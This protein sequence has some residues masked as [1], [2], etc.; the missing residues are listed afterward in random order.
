[1]FQIPARTYVIIPAFN[2]A[3]V[4]RSTVEG[5]LKAGYEVILVDDCST[6]DTNIVLERLN[7]HL[8]RHPVNLGQGASLQTGMDYAK[9]LNADYVIHFDADGQHRVEDIP[10]LLQPLIAQK[11]DITLGSR[12]MEESAEFRV[13]KR[14][15]ILLKAA[16]LVNGIFTGVWLS[17]AHNG[18]RGLSKKA[19]NKIE[20]SENGMAHATEILSEIHK[21]QLVVK[22]VPVKIKYTTYSHS[23]GQSAWRAFS[24]L[25]DLIMR[26][27]F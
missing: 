23:K 25:S 15:R 26:K 10:L 14:R 2:E 13:P 4:I 1:M 3:T 7:I 6:D 24:I 8:V 27:L 17:D 5:V 11:A 12:F 9:T 21:H 19:L 20:L 22:E 18:L 16:I